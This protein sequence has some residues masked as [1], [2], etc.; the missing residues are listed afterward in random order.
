[1]PGVLDP[2]ETAVPAQPQHA[3]LGRRLIISVFRFLI[4]L[5]LGALAG[6]GWGLWRSAASV[7]PGE[8]SSWKNCINMVSKLPFAGSRS[9][10]FADSSRRMYASSITNIA[11]TPSLK[12]AAFLSM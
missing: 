8:R 6:G 3:R 11:R 2:R 5:A 9:I 7:A 12:S 10:L 4:V 1:M